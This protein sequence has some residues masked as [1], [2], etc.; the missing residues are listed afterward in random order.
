[1]MGTVG[2][3][4]DPGK[5]F[6]GGLHPSTSEESM[7][8]YFSGFGQVND[9]K[10]MIDNVTRK[11]RGFGF[12]TFADARSAQD[13]LDKVPHVLDGKQI[14]PKKAVP[15]GP[16][17]S[18]ILKQMGKHEDQRNLSYGLSNVTSGAA[19]SRSRNPECKVFV[20]GISQQTTDNELRAYFSEYGNVMEVVI[21][22]DRNTGNIRGFAFVGFDNPDTVQRLLRIH[23]HQINGRTV[24]VKSCD[25]QGTKQ[26][27]MQNMNGQFMGAPGAAYGQADGSAGAYGQNAYGAYG[28]MLQQAGYA[29][30]PGAAAG[31]YG[32]GYAYGAAGYGALSGAATSQYGVASTS[33][34]ASQTTAAAGGAAAPGADYS[35]G[36]QMYGFGNY[37]QEASSFGPARSIGAD[38]TGYAS[39][40]TGALTAAY[41]G[42]ADAAAAYGVGVSYADTSAAF[43]RG[44]VQNSTNQRGYHPYVR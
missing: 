28:S 41:G 34:M 15:K 36:A 5:L 22:Q 38:L 32:A 31:P 17:Q 7:R 8:D 30:A 20:G 42:A 23:F 33:A 10:L 18:I 12:V 19:R 14:D 24:E 16:G 35:F 11:S 37:Q 39:V 6:V 29:Q 21:P 43:G 2:Q 40:G 9:C 27:Q 4:D 13:V 3:Q 44:T 26:R 1:M 25:E